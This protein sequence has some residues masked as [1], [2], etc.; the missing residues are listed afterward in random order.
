M[1]PGSGLI[2]RASRF[3]VTPHRIHGHAFDLERAGKVRGTE[4]ARHAR[5]DMVYL[6]ELVAP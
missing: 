6:L 3:R 5:E 1:T 4:V 2:E